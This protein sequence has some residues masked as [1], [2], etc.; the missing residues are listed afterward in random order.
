MKIELR[1]IYKLALKSRKLQLKI[2]ELLKKNEF[3]IPIHLAFGHEFVSSLVKFYFKKND[4]ILLTHR[5]IHFNSVFSK[6]IYSKYFKMTKK[7]NKN[8]FFS[9]GSMNFVDKNSNIIYSSSVLGNNI[10]V[11]CGVSKSY[12]NK[13]NVTICVTGDGAIEE[14]TFYE[15]LILAK[16]LKIP[17]L[18][19]IENNDWSM[20]T[21]IKERRDNIDFKILAKSLSVEYFKFGR[22]NF[23]KNINKYKKAINNCRKNKT[24]AICEF[25][26]KTLGT[27][28][29]SGKKIHYHHGPMKV[30][31]RNLIIGNPKDD[32]IYQIQKQIKKNENN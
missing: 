28:I 32:V 4:Q 14:G 10:P 25:D 12:K 7:K 9:E 23:S 3:R 8:I 26:V 21:S 22:F 16:Y 17:L 5:N 27:F 13:G 15:S 20:A 29:S 31:H 2:N 18:F 24:P 19:L 1:K 6:N 30:E 11:A